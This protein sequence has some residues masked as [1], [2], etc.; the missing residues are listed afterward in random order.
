MDTKTLIEHSRARFDH[1]AA[2]RLLREKYQAKMTFAHSGGL[3]KAGP[4][5][6]ALLQTCTAGNDIVIEDL[7]QNPIRVNPQELH[8]IVFERWQE[9]M[10]A[11][12]VEFDQL[13]Q[14]R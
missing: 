12:Q 8:K 6:L 9:Q 7:Y 2:R 11:W 1:A 14:Q 4:K 10:N 3:F 13:N 5:L